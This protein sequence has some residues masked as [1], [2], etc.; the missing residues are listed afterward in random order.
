MSARE[1]TGLPP[2]LN[3]ETLKLWLANSLVKPCIYRLIQ[4]PIGI[5][6]TYLLLYR[7]DKLHFTDVLYTAWNVWSIIL[8][9]R[10]LERVVIFALANS[11]KALNES[12]ADTIIY[13][14]FTARH[15]Y[16]SAVRYW[17]NYCAV[18]CCDVC[19]Y[20]FDNNMSAAGLSLSVI[21]S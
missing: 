20:F 14:K 13:R 21:T 5:W 1:R 7:G 6:D 18:R 10:I 17:H 4:R 12:F 16:Y 2:S 3:H 11:S 15:S 8:E 19:Y 9:W